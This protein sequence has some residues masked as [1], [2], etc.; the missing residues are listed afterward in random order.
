[1]GKIRRYHHLNDERGTPVRRARLA[2]K[3]TMTLSKAT[4]ETLPN[5]RGT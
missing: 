4:E 2:D 1:M 3:L 5:E